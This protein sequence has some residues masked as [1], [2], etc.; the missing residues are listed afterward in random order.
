[1]RDPAPIDHKDPV[2]VAAWLADVTKGA[3]EIH[4]LAIDATARK[5]QR[6]H[7]RGYLRGILRRRFHALSQLLAALAPPGGAA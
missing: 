7:S 6:R 5:G 3:A 2:A 4:D 1:M